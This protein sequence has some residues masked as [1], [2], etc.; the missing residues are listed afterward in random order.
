VRGSVENNR[1]KWGELKECMEG[2]IER[3]DFGGEG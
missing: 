1:T 2:Q 3:F